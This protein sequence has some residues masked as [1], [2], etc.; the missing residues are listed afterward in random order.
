MG[1]DGVMVVEQIKIRVNYNIIRP[2]RSQGFDD[3]ED[4]L[5]R[6]EKGTFKI[7]SRQG[8]S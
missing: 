1:R 8:E 4:D 5:P 2:T 3:G 6:A 7:S